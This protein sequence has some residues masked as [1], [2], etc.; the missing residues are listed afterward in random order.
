MTQDKPLLIFGLLDG[1]RVMGYVNR[2]TSTEIFM[3]APMRV[4]VRPIHGDKLA[5]DL[6]D[7]VV[8]AEKNAELSLCKTGV[9]FSFKPGESLIQGYVDHLT[10]ISNE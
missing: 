1:S 9:L 8:G 7:F 6:V 5:V 10:R 2:E 3:R 4:L